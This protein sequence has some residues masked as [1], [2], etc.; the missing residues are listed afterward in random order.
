MAPESP[1]ESIR[2]IGPRIRALREAAGLTQERLAYEC[3]HSKGYLSDVES[4]KR[5]PSLEFLAGL[6]ARLDQPLV[7]PLQAPGVPASPR[8]VAAP[9]P[10][11]TEPA[12]RADAEP[13]RVPLSLTHGR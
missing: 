13:P 3:G 2:R 7:A 6:M 10:P 4:G 8:P 9:P 5:V 11:A 12:L 1:H